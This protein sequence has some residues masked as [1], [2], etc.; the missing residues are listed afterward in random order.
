[1]INNNQ[2]A[3]HLKPIQLIDFSTL[4]TSSMNIKPSH[5]ATGSIS[6]PKTKMHSLSDKYVV[7][8]LSPNKSQHQQ[9]RQIIEEEHEKVSYIFE[10]RKWK[11]F[12]EKKQ[13]KFQNLKYDLK[14]LFENQPA[15]NEPLPL[16]NMMHDYIPKR[17]QV[18]QQKRQDPGQDKKMSKQEFDRLN[19]QALANICECK[20]DFRESTW[21]HFNSLVF[22]TLKQ[23][24][25]KSKFDKRYDQV[26]FQS[27]K[28]PNLPLYCIE[29]NQFQELIK[30]SNQYKQEKA[31][32]QRKTFSSDEEISEPKS[33]FIDFTKIYDDFQSQKHFLQSS[34]QPKKGKGQQNL[35]FLEKLS[36]QN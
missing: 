6:K 23:K 29:T 3:T 14:D 35:N 27:I 18:P 24:E 19:N 13:V 21:K 15:F 4:P 33:G 31:Q 1:M 34:K 26:K 12:D 36:N 25:I 30:L 16:Y 8:N 7:I 5:R 20:K 10:L 11:I 28:K 17:V 32:E 22:N 2:R 9:Q